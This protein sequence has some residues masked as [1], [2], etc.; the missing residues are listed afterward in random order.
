MPHPSTSSSIWKRCIQVLQW[1]FKPLLHLYYVPVTTP[2]SSSWVV[3]NAQA[4][5]WRCENQWAVRILPQFLLL[6]LNVKRLSDAM[7]SSPT[8]I[9]Q[10]CRQLGCCRATT[11]T[12]FWISD[13]SCGVAACNSRQSRCT[14]KT[15]SCLMWK[16]QLMRSL[17]IAN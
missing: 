14:C 8:W 1:Q 15:R 5:T 12:T 4:K 3:V 6:I 16:L 10:F 9:T 2:S 7:C 17:V 13:C 11:I